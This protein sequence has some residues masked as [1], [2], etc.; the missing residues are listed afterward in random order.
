[1][2]HSHYF[3]MHLLPFFSPRSNW[4]G[5][6]KLGK[7]IGKNWRKRDKASTMHYRFWMGCQSHLLDFLRAQLTRLTVQAEV[8]EIQFHLVLGHI[9]DFSF[10]WYTIMLFRQVEEWVSLRRNFWLWGSGWVCPTVVSIYPCFSFLF[11]SFLDRHSTVLN[12]KR[13]TAGSWMVSSLSLHLSV[14]LHVPL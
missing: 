6:G 11:S 7:R 8:V 4:W 5:R 1:M 10:W 2:G 14:R 9:K 12:L 3:L 13:Y